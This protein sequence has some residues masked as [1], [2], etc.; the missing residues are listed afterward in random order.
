MAERTKPGAIAA[1]LAGLR[2][3]VAATQLAVVGIGGIGAGN[4]EQV[5]RAGATVWR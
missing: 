5:L 1:G 3:V 4:A 2:A